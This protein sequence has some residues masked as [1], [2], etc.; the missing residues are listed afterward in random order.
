MRGAFGW[1]LGFLDVT[2]I[3]IIHL[4]LSLRNPIF[5]AVPLFYSVLVDKHGKA[6]T[7]LMVDGVSF[8]INKRRA[9]SHKRSALDEESVLAI[10]TVIKMTQGVREKMTSTDPLRN[11]L[12]FVNDLLGPRGT[13][14]YSVYHF[15]EESKA[16]RASNLFPKAIG[17]GLIPS[18]ITPSAL[19]RTTAVLEWF[20]TGSVLSAA[21]KIG[22]TT[23]VVI[24]H[25]IPEALLA[26]WNVRLVRRYHNLVLA[27]AAAHESHC[28]PATDFSSPLELERFIEN[29]LEEHSPSSSKLA[30]MMHERFRNPEHVE[31]QPDAA[32]PHQASSLVVGISPEILSVVYA[33]RDLAYEKGFDKMTAG[34]ASE[35]RHLPPQAIVDLAD[36]LMARLPDHHDPAFRRAHVEAEQL[37][38]KIVD[39][40]REGVDATLKPER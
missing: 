18:R 14:Y 1:M 35:G 4:F 3:A 21:R 34:D 16:R 20:R 10:R 36:L 9:K 15:G 30:A 29:A 13:T 11:R 39:S 24:K 38:I 19:R 7:S 27:T 28:L 8:V 12:F 5:N 37:A 2:D 33:Y 17:T 26:A 31:P 23:R 25:Y 32:E 6:N 40:M 22:N